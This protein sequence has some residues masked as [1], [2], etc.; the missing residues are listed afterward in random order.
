MANGD[1]VAQFGFDDYGFFLDGTG[2]QNSHLRWVDD[3]GAHGV[4]KRADIGEGESANVI[5]AA[6]PKFQFIHSKITC[7]LIPFCLAISS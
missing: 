2:C 5:S 7:I 6:C 4:A 1:G 3:G